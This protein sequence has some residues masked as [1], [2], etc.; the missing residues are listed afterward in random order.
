[1]TATSRR[2]TG[3]HMPE[4]VYDPF[5]KLKGTPMTGAEAKRLYPRIWH[6]FH[7]DSFNH[8]ERKRQV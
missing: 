3:Q 5:E 4:I 8:E 1:M 2:L 6:L 7:G